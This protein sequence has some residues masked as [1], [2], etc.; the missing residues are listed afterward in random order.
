VAS[1]KKIEFYL[2]Q[3]DQ[4]GPLGG[5]SDATHKFTITVDSNAKK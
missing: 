1:L 2:V 4:E 3:I 5:L